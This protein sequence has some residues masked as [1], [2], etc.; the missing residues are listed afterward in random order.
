MS[1]AFITGSREY[2]QPRLDSDIDLVVRVSDE[3]YER[4]SDLRDDKSTPAIMFGR[5]NLIAC[6]TDE[7]FAAWL[8]A[9]R[10]TRIESDGGKN[11]VPKKNTIRLIDLL[12]SWAGLSVRQ[13]PPSCED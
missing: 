9:T 12:E 11:P 7:E 8:I 13:Q 3:T 2:G 5:L 1:E 6:R 10:R 4:L